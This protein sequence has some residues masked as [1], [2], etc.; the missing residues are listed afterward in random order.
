MLGL[1]E[2]GQ[3]VGVGRAAEISTLTE[4]LEQRQA[5]LHEQHAALPPLGYRAQG[6]LGGASRQ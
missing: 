3:A 5:G 6:A 2:V 4:T 1:H